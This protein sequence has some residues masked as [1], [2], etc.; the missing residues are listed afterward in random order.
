MAMIDYGALLRVDG[1]LI[2]KNQDM[3]MDASDTGYVAKNIL[4]I[5]SE[6]RDING[7]YFVVAGDEH[8]CIAFYK[9]LYKVISDKKVIYTNWDM[10]FASETR[11]FPNL[12]TL[13]VSRLSTYYEVEKME[14]MGTWRDYVKEN[15]VGATGNE[16]LSELFNGT[17]RYKRFKKC[18]KRVYRVNSHGGLYKSRPY[19]FLAEWDYNGHHYEV[20]FG[21]GI[22]NDKTVWNE[23]KNAAYSFRPEEIKLIDSWFTTK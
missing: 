21:Y 10:P 23:I 13:K 8:F 11:F 15:W 12:P 19:R 18:L 2:N 9:G 1:K 7:D 5:D 17:E 14:S 22:D 3:F 16:T 20:I 4:D 6:V